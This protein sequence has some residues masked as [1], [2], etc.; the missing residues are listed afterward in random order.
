LVLPRS[1]V[2]LTSALTSA[3]EGSRVPMGARRAAP[4]A[5]ASGRYRFGIGLVLDPSGRPISASSDKDREL[6]PLKIEPDEASPRGAVCTGIDPLP[7]YRKEHP[8][9]TTNRSTLLLQSTHCWPIS[10]FVNR[11]ANEQVTPP[12]RHAH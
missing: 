6:V 5:K 12:R 7:P 1:W 8:E 9:M 3:A 10:P 11:R 4:A 2:T